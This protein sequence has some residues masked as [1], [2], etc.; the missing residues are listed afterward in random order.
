[1]VMRPVKVLISFGLMKL[2]WCSLFLIV[3]LVY[4]INKGDMML[5]ILFCMVICAVIT[6]INYKND[7]NLFLQFIILVILGVAIPLLADF[8]KQLIDHSVFEIDFLGV[9]VDLGFSLIITPIL[10]IQALNGRAL[11][12][13]MNKK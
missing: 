9:L 11:R 1:M 7:I 2:L 10:I 5:I 4:L 12:L 8:F 6:V 3:Y 13:K